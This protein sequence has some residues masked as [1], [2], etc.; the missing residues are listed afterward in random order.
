[1]I[2]T[3]KLLKILDVSSKAKEETGAYP[4]MGIF[5][6]KVLEFLSCNGT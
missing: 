4:L 2:K 5:Y 1:M 6:A 3:N